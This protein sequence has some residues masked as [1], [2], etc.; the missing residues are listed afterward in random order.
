MPSPIYMTISLRLLIIAYTRYM[1]SIFLDQL[2]VF[3]VINYHCLL[4]KSHFF[5][6]RNKPLA[7]LPGG[8]KFGQKRYIILTTV[9]DG[10][11]T[12]RTPG[13]LF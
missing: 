9:S 11:Q 4:A 10:R 8:L 5:E 13:F 6:I 7:R 2:K 3:D 1:C 12:I